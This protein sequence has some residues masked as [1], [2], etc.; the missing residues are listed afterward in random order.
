MHADLLG[1]LAQLVIWTLYSLFLGLLTLWIFI[2]ICGAWQGW[3]L[4]RQ[5]RPE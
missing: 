3:K 4:R 5:R 2:L 1:S